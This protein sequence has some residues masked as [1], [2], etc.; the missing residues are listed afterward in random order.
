MISFN[1]S[2]SVVLYDLE[3]NPNSS[4]IWFYLFVLYLKD[5]PC[6]SKW[7]GSRE[8]VDRKTRSS[9]CPLLKAAASS[10][11]LCWPHLSLRL[12]HLHFHDCSLFASAALSSDLV[13]S[14]PPST[15]ET[16]PH[17]SVLFPACSYQVSP[18]PTPVKVVFRVLKWL[19]TPLWALSSGLYRAPY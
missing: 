1:L 13:F 3:R 7:Q 2:S 4:R 8:G 6:L 11:V 5:T 17:L 16:P 14:L 19:C 10:P 15:V 9:S 18:V 12:R